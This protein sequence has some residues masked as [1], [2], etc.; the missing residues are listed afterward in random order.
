MLYQHK[1]GISLRKVQRTD[2]DF[3]FGLK[4]E[5]WW[6][7]QSTLIINMDDQTR[8]FNTMPANELFMIGL[9]GKTRIGV[10]G[11]KIDN[12]SR[13]VQASA[14][15]LKSRRNLGDLVKGVEAGID[16][17]FEVLNMHRIDGSVT[18]YHYPSL[19]IYKMVGFKEE[20]RRRQ[21]VYKAGRYYDSVHLG[22]LREEWL[23]SER[24]QSY[25]GSCTTAFDVVLAEKMVQK[26]RKTLG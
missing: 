4:S 22:L 12:I 26:S 14:N 20:G 9:K 19:R 13:C 15:I 11:L 17:I 5:S 7:N 21:G 18:E 1:N 3:L 2:L 8:W 6:G 23:A 10:T 16:F 24:I 25:N